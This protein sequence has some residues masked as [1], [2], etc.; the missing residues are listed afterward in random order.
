ML[1]FRQ[2]TATRLFFNDSSLNMLQQLNS[3]TIRDLLRRTVFRIGT[4]PVNSEAEISSANRR[5]TWPGW[6]LQI[7]RVISLND[8][9][10]NETV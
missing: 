8:K 6:R 1:Y 9:E 4:A 7:N 5:N 10:I 2:Q 3:D